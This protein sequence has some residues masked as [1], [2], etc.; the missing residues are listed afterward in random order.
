M[1]LRRPLLLALALGSALLLSAAAAD[2]TTL[3]QQEAQLRRDVQKLQ[4]RARAERAK[5]LGVMRRNMTRGS[6]FWTSTG[7]TARLRMQF[8][9]IHGRTR[10]TGAVTAKGSG[11]RSGATITATKRA[12]R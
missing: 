3:R 11:K 5:A 6:G 10:I 4:R 7:D 2:L 8:S 1:P 12:Y 9:S